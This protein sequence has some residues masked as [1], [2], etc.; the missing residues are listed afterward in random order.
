MTTIVIDTAAQ[1]TNYLSII[2]NEDFSDVKRRWL[3]L[4]LWISNCISYCVE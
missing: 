2:P 1:P 4:L 3:W